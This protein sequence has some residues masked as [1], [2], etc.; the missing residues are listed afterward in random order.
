MQVNKVDECIQLWWDAFGVDFMYRMY[1][2]YECT[3]RMDVRSTAKTGTPT[4]STEHAST[5]VSAK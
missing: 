2:N 1:Y 4:T 3:S 5:I